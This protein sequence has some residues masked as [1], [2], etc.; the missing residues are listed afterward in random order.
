MR[1][2]IA[3]IDRER[4]VQQPLR[5]FVVAMSELVDQGDCADNQSPDV[6]TFRRLRSGAIALARVEMRLDGGDNVAG[7]LVLHREDVVQSAVVPVGPDMAALLGV[8]QLGSDA[9]LLAGAADASL[10]GIADAKLAGDGADIDPPV[11]VGEGRIAGDDEQP[12][13]AGQSRCQIVCHPVG[14]K[15]LLGIVAQVRQRQHDDRWFVGQQEGR[16]GCG[17]PVP[18]A[19]DG[20]GANRLGDVLEPVAAKVTKPGG[21]LALDLLVDGLRQADAAACRQALEACGDIDAVAQDVLTLNQ[22]DSLLNG[23]SRG[24]STRRPAPNR[25][26][27]LAGGQH[28]M[29]IFR[30]KH[31]QGRVECGLMM[32]P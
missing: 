27:R 20:V 7:D 32:L 9:D 12:A 23:G 8:D 4:A 14:E 29:S 18:T 10:E 25:T 26:R 28:R 30:K 17:R 16:S 13:Q 15:R 22:N 1:A 11:L 5:L 21:D 2:R 3:R 24:A 31:Y 6:D 19:D